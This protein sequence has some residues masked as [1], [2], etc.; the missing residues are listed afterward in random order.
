MIAKFEYV[1]HA[2]RRRGL[3]LAFL[4]SVVGAAALVAGC[5][6]SG[7]PPTPVPDAGTGADTGIVD[8]H[9][10]DATVHDSS[11]T[12]GSATDA[13]GPDAGAAADASLDA[14]SNVGIIDAGGDA[15]ASLRIDAP[16]CPTIDAI[17]ASPSSIEVGFS[18][19][20][21]AAASDL[22]NSPAPLAYAW[23]ASSGTFGSATAANTTFTCTAPGVVTLTLVVSDGD[24]TDTGTVPI[25]CTSSPVRD[26]G[27][28]A[29]PH[30]AGSDAA[31]PHDA[32]PPVTT[33]SILS[34]KNAECLAC[35]QT[36]GCVDTGV[37]CEASA[38]NA[39]AG[40]AAG[41]ARSQLCLDTLSCVIGANCAASGTGSP[42]YCGAARGTTCLSAGAADGA[43]RSQEERGLETT[44]P[45]SIATGFGNTVLGGGVANVL[46]QCL[47]D[48]A[49]T[50]CFQ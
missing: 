14:E 17:S 12:D 36:N 15:D 47:N 21:T 45:V 23:S 28:D 29:A 33:L 43:C 18:V 38:G 6:D 3:F 37:L 26:A 1:P 48:S 13:Q 50:T 7:E 22:D 20:L 46:V 40:P 27:S 10:I 49:C 9:P 8:P 31:P 44:D 11:T 16:V 39:A 30:D 19:A 35:A 2:T 25:T 32:A 5:S 24:C 34:G 41:D 42:C 4:S